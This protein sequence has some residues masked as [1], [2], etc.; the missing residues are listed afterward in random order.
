MRLI[1]DQNARKFFKTKKRGAQKSFQKHIPDV[2][3]SKGNQQFTIF[4]QFTRHRLKTGP[5]PRL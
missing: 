1:N 4:D 3:E 5:K 2:H